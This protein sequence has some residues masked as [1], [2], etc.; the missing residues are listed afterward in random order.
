[1]EEIDLKELFQV[2]WKKRILIIIII[3]VFAIIGAIYTKFFVTP[4][5]KSTTSLLLAT[6]SGTAEIPST[7]TSITTTDVTINSKLVSTYSE[8]VTSSKVLR[9]VITNLGLD[10]NENTLKKM[11]EVTTS[12]DTEFIKITVESE[13][14]VLATKI[15][16][17]IADVSIDNVVE[18]YGVENLHVVDKAEIPNSPSNINHFRDIVIFAFIGLVVAIIYVLI[19]NMLDTT[20]KSEEDIE[21]NFGLTVL[22]TFPMYEDRIEKKKGKRRK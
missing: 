4:K 19:L 1:M 14:P 17:E 16:N 9:T 5:Y 21:K 20:I 7:D 15:A 6:N 10:M 3:L 22:A 18:Y 2:F 8:L 12:D 13:D 11:I